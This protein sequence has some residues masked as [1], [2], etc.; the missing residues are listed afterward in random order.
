MSSLNSYFNDES[1]I[2]RGDIQILLDKNKRQFDTYEFRDG[3]LVVVNR[4]V[5]VHDANQS[6]SNDCAIYKWYNGKL[7]FL[8]LLGAE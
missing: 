4:S 7:V 5:C 6:E 2:F 8:E 3:K 1:K